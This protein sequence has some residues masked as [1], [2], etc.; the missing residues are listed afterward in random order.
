MR[1]FGLTVILISTS[2]SLGAHAQDQTTAMPQ[3]SLEG[4]NT[5]PTA[6]PPSVFN[7][8][9]RFDQSDAT[10][11]TP[12]PDGNG[13]SPEAVDRL[14]FGATPVDVKQNGVAILRAQ[15]ATGDA[16]AQL[17]LGAAYEFGLGTDKDPAGAF[18][19]YLE[20]A[21]KNN[22]A[23]QYAVGRAYRS[24]LGTDPNFLQ[25]FTWLNSA[26]DN[27]QAEAAVDLAKAYQF[28][29][30]TPEDVGKSEQYWRKALT[31]NSPEAYLGYAGFLVDKKGAQP[32]DG[33]VKDLIWKAADSG[34]PQAL[35]AAFGIAVST[36][37]RAQQSRWM[38][39]LKKQSDQ[40]DTTS[41]IDL[42]DA[43][44]IEESAH[45]DP[46]AALAGR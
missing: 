44:L 16:D 43:Y 34:N 32:T 19:N 39:K 24:G 30:G 13:R 20:A 9:S 41:S 1:L 36:D 42:A 37:D 2:I 28:G 31:L 17:R 38:D 22:P 10:N 3:R 14:I 4:W 6:L 45:F 33:A 12:I 7:K 40:G 25:S 46:A 8:L 21:R 26:Y 27:G 29:L 11:Q 23:S 15:A 35:S 18:V 5:Q